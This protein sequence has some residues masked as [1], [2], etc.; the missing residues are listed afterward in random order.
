[1]DLHI[2]IDLDNTIIDYEQVFAPVAAELGLLP[3]GE[4]TGDKEAIKSR[5]IKADPSEQTWMRLQGQ[6]YGRHIGL[7]LPYPGVVEGLAQLK[8]AGARLSIVSHKTRHGHFDPARIDLW[9]AAREWLALNNL[10]DPEGA[11]IAHEDVHF[12]L[13]RE[14]KVERIR[15]IG[16]AVFIDDLPEV[17]NHPSFPSDVRAMWFAGPR[18]VTERRGLK[19]FKTWR[20]VV[21]TLMGTR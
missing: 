16:C 6:V 9:Q 21:D 14:A 4:A 11:G 15:A 12:E 13:T 5:L 1:M 18:N 8:L 7:A 20:D 17:L 3:K 2:G 10:H 19:P